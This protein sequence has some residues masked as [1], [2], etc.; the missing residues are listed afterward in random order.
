MR[1]VAF[2]LARF[3]CYGVA[4]VLALSALGAAVPAFLLVVLDANGM[5]ALFFAAI[6]FMVAVP[7]AWGAWHFF[8]VAHTARL[9]EA[10]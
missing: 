10:E 5:L 2:V 7:L 8:D 4:L 1:T 6:L 9:V 3:A